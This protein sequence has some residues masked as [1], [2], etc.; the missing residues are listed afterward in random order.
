MENS[1]RNQIISASTLQGADVRSSSDESIGEIKDLMIDVSSGEISYAVLSVSTGF[2]NLDSKY[3][4]VP[5]EAFEFQRFNDDYTGQVVVLD[6][7]KEKLENSPGFDK[8]N[9]PTH[10]DSVFIDSVNSYYGIQGN[11]GNRGLGNSDYDDSR[12]GDTSL[13]GS[14]LDDSDLEG[15]RLDDTRTTGSRYE[16]SD[17]DDSRFDDSNLGDSRRDNTRF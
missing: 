14:V 5:L 1:M 13:G 15:S 4:A 17:R 3:F 2:L 9:W 10:P 8:D 12:L 6:V 11:R 16:N 7:S